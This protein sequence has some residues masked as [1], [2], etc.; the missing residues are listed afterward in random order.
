MDPQ[1]VFLQQVAEPIAVDQVNRWRA[2]TG[3]L[4]LRVVRTT[5]SP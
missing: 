4:G 5:A 2:V 3:G 1:L